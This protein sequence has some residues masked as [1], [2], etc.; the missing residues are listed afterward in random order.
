M[1]T[2]FPPAGWESQP[3]KSKATGIATAAVMMT[4][5]GGLATVGLIFAQRIKDL[6]AQ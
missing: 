1:T 3:V 5:L 4:V 6:Y 2:L